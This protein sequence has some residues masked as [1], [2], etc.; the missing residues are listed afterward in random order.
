MANSEDTTRKFDE[1]PVWLA[2]VL[3]KIETVKV[4]VGQ[5]RG[6]VTELRESVEA[7]NRETKP[8]GETLEAMRVDIQQLKDGQVE[9][10]DELRKEMRQGFYLLDRRLK[11]MNNIVMRFEGDL[12]GLDERLEAL[13]GQQLD[14]PDLHPSPLSPS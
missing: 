2:L 13:E 8:L 11:G 4:E 12:V 6:E 10:R 1:Q 3:D 7:R 9:F 14:R 5:L